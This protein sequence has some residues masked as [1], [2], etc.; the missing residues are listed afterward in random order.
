MPVHPFNVQLGPLLITGYGI[1][2]MASFLVGGWL[3]ARQL[4]ERGFNRDYSSDIIFAALIGGILGARLWYMAL[5]GGSLFQ[6]GGLVWYGGFL[7]GV[8]AVLFNGWRLRV[9][10]RWTMQVMGATL[11]GAYAIGRVGCFLVGDDYGRPTTLPWAVSFPEGLPPTTA[12]SLAEFG[13]KLPA[14]TDPTALLA[15]HPT[16]LY[17]VGLMFLAFTVLWRWRLKDWGT[18]AILG[19]YLVMAGMERFFVEIFRAKD[20]R[21]LAGFTLAQLTSV[22]LVVV[23]SAIFLR[24]RNASQVEPGAYLSLSQNPAV[25]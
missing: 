20:D 22:L 11:A 23:G 25:K 18:G 14:G 5:H 12:G 9:P 21:F 19:L 3:I 4:Q 13:V 15:V 17:E 7:G 8:A 10:A 24:L 2:M 6:R 1:M 16:Q